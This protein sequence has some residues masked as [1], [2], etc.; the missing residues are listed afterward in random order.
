[1]LQPGHNGVLC[2]RQP[3]HNALQRGTLGYCLGQG[4]QQQLQREALSS[5]GCLCPG[6]CGTVS[7]WGRCPL[8]LLYALSPELMVLVS[9]YWEVTRLLGGDLA[10]HPLGMPW[11]K[12]GGRAGHQGLHP[13][14]APPHSPGP[15]WCHGE[16]RS[17]GVTR[18][19]P[20]LSV[21][22]PSRSL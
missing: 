15:R 9:V 22:W 4:E 17:P 3:C 13:L 21:T 1:M 11:H 18:H 2:V 20:P 10:P 8:A 6:H 16:E 5:P 12:A 7:P 14:L 19:W